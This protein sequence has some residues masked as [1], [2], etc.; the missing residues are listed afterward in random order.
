MAGTHIAPGSPLAIKKYSAALFIEQQ[1]R[2][3]FAKA[4]SAAA[5]KEGMVAAALRGKY[6]APTGMPIVNIMDLA[7]S[8]GDLV[9]Y[10]IM[11][12]L[13]GKPTM[14]DRR[15][16]GR[17]M[18]LKFASNELRINQTRAG[19]DPGGVMTKKRTAYDLRKLSM[20]NLQRWNTNLVDNRMMVHLAGARGTQVGGEWTSIPFETDPDF[21]D[22]LINPV[23]PP[24]YNRR[25]VVGNPNG[26]YGSISTLDT[27][28]KMSR[29]F[30]DQLRIEIDNDPTPL[31]G[32]IPDFDG[33]SQ[34]DDEALYIIYLSPAGYQQFRNSG[35][36]KDYNDMMLA[37]TTRSNQW[38]HPVF[39]LGDLLY[40][41]FII[42]RR[43]KMISFAAGAS[44]REY[45]SSGAIVT[46]TAPVSFDRAI[47]LGAQAAV[48]A[49]GS[50]STTGMPLKWHE[51]LTD[52]DARLEISTS[53]IDGMQKLRFDLDGTLTDFG[54]ATID[55]H[56]VL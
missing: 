41:N 24:T 36:D 27:A 31:Q 28:N 30:L 56:N 16:S 33:A 43:A 17:M 20:G 10:D 15:L 14:G 11:G 55:Y 40:Q 52:H 37:A 6:Q 8:A 54:V 45:N 49:M 44:V 25:F 53:M 35:T 2:N 42:R 47:V 48:Y 1:R 21:A 32:V 22:I 13:R 7:S 12:L 34:E 26:G 46:T 23:T 51:E 18:N 3:T 4:L 50:D 39:R 5:P 9:S 19:V 29:D 38:K